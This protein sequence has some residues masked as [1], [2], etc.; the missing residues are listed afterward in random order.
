MGVSAASSVVR[1][2]PSVRFTPLSTSSSA[3]MS[4]CSRLMASAVRSKST[5]LSMP[6][7]C[8]MLYVITRNLIDCCD[9]FLGDV[10]Q[11][12][13]V[14]SN[15]PKALTI[16]CGRGHKKADPNTIIIIRLKI[17]L[18]QKFQLVLCLFRKTLRISHDRILQR[19]MTGPI[20]FLWN[21]RDG[22]F[23]HGL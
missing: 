11:Q 3:T 8:W 4:G 1:S 12:P 7:P 15:K 10:L 18:Q 22:P 16:N 6:A 19:G 21:L 5:F 9:S 23:H 14:N 17:L 2:R 20:R 13:A